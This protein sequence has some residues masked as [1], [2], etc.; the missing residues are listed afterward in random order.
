MAKPKKM[1][2]VQKVQSL[3]PRGLLVTRTLAMP[4]DINANGDIF[5]GWVLSQ[6]DIAGGLV[7]KKE[8][9]QRVVTVAI[10]SMSFL[11]PVRVGEILCCYGEILKIGRTSLAI[12][13]QAWAEDAYH[14]S[15]TLVT[16]GIFTYVAVNIKGKPISANKTVSPKA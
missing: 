11:Q 8:S 6:M 3:T 4:A 10:D 1:T 16:E 15:L 13:L 2:T 9:H 14:S 7:A 12:K 5:G